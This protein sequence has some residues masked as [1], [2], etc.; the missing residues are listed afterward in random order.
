[1]LAGEGLIKGRIDSLDHQIPAL[2]LSVA[3]IDRQIH[4][5][6]FDLPL[7]CLHAANIRADPRGPKTGKV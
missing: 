5:H 4:N 2:W 3:R 1:M 7:I 6:L